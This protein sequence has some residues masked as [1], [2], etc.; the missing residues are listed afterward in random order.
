MKPIRVGK[1][2]NCRCRS[3]SLTP[4]RYAFGRPAFA[5]RTFT[6]GAA[7][8]P[9]VFGHEMMGEV[10]AMGN[11]I[12]TDS[13]RRPLKE[14]DRVAYSYFF[15]CARCYNCLRGEFGACK[16]R[17]GRKTLDEWAVCNGGFAQYYYLRSPHYVFKLPESISSAAAAPSRGSP[18][19]KPVRSSHSAGTQAPIASSRLAFTSVTMGTI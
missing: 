10:A 17:S 14:G 4:F 6:S 13:L 1:C 3:S 16:F 5:D 9:F 2:E 11:K 12:T 15:P 18:L 7:R 19:Q 8:D